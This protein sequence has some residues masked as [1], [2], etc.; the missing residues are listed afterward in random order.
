MERCFGCLGVELK[1][2]VHWYT[3][4]YLLHLASIHNGTP[5]A[6]FNKFK[7]GCVCVCVCWETSPV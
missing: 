2:R 3:K 5:P 6:S 1:H 7:D 4:Q